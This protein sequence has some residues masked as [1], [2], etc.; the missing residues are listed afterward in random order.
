MITTDPS[1]TQR[2]EKNV[3]DAIIGQRRL[4]YERFLTA[5]GVTVPDSKFARPDSDDPAVLARYDEMQGLLH[6]YGA[7]T[8]NITARGHRTA[9]QTAGDTPG[10]LPLRLQ[11]IESL[12]RWLPDAAATEAFDEG[13]APLIAAHVAGLEQTVTQQAARLVKE[14]REFGEMID[15]RDQLHDVA[16]RLAYAIAPIEQIGEHSSGNN[17]W[18]NALD[19]L[20]EQHKLQAK[21]SAALTA[22]NE[23]LAGYPACDEHTEDDPISCGWKRAV[24]DA[25]AALTAATA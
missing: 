15:H 18:D 3:A 2:A 4:A 14:E 5:R 16:D 9:P 1:T 21:Q 20:T 23:A 24:A 17:P 6:T 19:V 13:L 12:Q 25:R 10:E 11:I 22:V 8:A 7:V